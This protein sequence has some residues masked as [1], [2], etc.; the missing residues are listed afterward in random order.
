MPSMV[1]AA[2]CGMFLRAAASEAA[3]ATALFPGTRCSRAYRS[4]DPSSGAA[5]DGAG[6]STDELS[7]PVGGFPIPAQRVASL[8]QRVAR[9]PVKVP[10]ARYDCRSLSCDEPRPEP[11]SFRLL[12]SHN[13]HR[14]D[15]LNRMNML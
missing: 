7:G 9:T 6:D 13:A 10:V 12:L 3:A 8:V 1:E 5:L 11:V 4:L 14:V 15:E 2:R